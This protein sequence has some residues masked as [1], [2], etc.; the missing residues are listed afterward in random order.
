MKKTLNERIFDEVKFILANSDDGWHATFDFDKWYI[1]IEPNDTLDIIVTDKVDDLGY[2]YNLAFECSLEDL[3]YDERNDKYI[4][5][6]INYKRACEL[7]KEYGSW[8]LE[9]GKKRLNQSCEKLLD[10]ISI[11]QKKYTKIV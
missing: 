9:H 3:E 4:K 6:K 2:S 10:H 11:Y 7:Y 1:T 8:L 5:D